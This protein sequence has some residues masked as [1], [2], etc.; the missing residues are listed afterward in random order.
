MK[1]SILL[2]LSSFL[3][4]TSV[5]F[6]QDKLTTLSHTEGKVELY[7]YT[8]A[9]KF[10]TLTS[11]IQGKCLK[12]TGEI[13]DVSKKGEFAFIFDDTRLKL[14]IK[15]CQ[16]EIDIVSRKIKH[17]ESEVIRNQKLLSSESITEVQFNDLVFQ[18]DLALLEN[19][20]RENQMN[21]LHDDLKKYVVTAPANYTL[22]ERYL[23]EGALAQPGVPLALYGDYERLIVPIAVTFDQFNA[24]SKVKDLTVRLVDYDKTVKAKILRRHSRFIEDSRKILIDLEL[25]EYPEKKN[26]GIKVMLQINTPNTGS[27][28]VTEKALQERYD[29]YFVVTEDDKRI[30]VKVLKISD[31]VAEIQGDGLSVGQKLKLR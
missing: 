16:T 7:G 31:G 11:E 19:E 12:T 6:S 2:V 29:E 9:Y 22:V 24:L 15:Q 13:G 23:E 28:S 26:G 3:C 20:L 18:R 5:I 10:V 30:R 4:M 8:R 21:Q 25:L 1:T 17:L 14:L 27:F